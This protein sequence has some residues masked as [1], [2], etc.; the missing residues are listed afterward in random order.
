MV[1]LVW[2]Y[3]THNHALTEIDKVQQLKEED[4]MKEETKS[5]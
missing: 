5:G 3:L 2:Q 1:T 4:G